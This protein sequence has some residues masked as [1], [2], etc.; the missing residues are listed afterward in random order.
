MPRALRRIIFTLFVLLFII[1]ATTLLFYASGYRYH[2]GKRVIEKTGKLIVET[3]PRGARI[4]VAGAAVQPLQTPTSISYLLSGE[5]EL[6]IEKDG[7]FPVR[8]RISIAPGVSTVVNDIVLI[9]KEEPRL[10]IGTD[11]VKEAIS[12]ADIIV[13]HDG[14]RVFDF[15]VYP[16]RLSER[17]AASEP[18]GV[19]RISESGAQSA[20]KTERGW[21]I[22]SKGEEIFFEKED[23]SILDIRFAKG[24]D[25][26]YARTAQGIARFEPAKRAFIL[27]VKRTDIVSYVVTGTSLFL[28]R[29][30]L[31]KG[32]VLEEV[33]LPSGANVRTISDLPAI[34]DILESSDGT[35]VLQGIGKSLYLFDARAQQAAFQLVSDARA[36]VFT[37]KERFFSFNDFEIWE[38]LFSHERY[39]RSLVTRKSNPIVTILPF[40][41]RQLM[42]TVAQNGELHLRRLGARESGELLLATFDAIVGIALNQKEDTLFIVGS[43]N[44]KQG[45]YAMTL[46][47]EEQV[48][49][50]VK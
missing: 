34:T 32:L 1:T 44:G 31:G 43:I 3:Q 23:S 5:Y 14:K 41:T 47:E 24:S 2:V 15:D 48:F 50:L 27:L 45:I 11:G 17:F 18:I 20:I 46:I 8:K 33:G 40:T 13:M 37:N 9:K 6:T 26:A 42:V 38:H 16:E 7:Y 22:S 12:I 4:I 29:E 35:L 49:P 36:V 28:F 30:I 19:L 39:S 21:S 25:E 10:L